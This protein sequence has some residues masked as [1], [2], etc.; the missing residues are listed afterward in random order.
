MIS[1]FGFIAI[2]NPFQKQSIDVPSDHDLLY[3][4]LFCLQRVKTSFVCSLCSKGVSAN[5]VNTSQG[6][7]TPVV[8][9]SSFMICFCVQNRDKVILI[10]SVH[11]YKSFVT[12][13]VTRHADDNIIIWKRTSVEKERLQC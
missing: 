1:S 7:V 8:I 10:I 12:I 9:V 3:S 4:W 5:C 2:L 11:V 6:V 13:V